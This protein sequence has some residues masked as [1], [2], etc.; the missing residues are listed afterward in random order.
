MSLRPAFMILSSFNLP[1]L[2]PPSVPLSLC[3]FAVMRHGRIVERGTHRQLIAA[4]GMY[5][6]LVRHQQLQSDVLGST[7]TSGSAGTG[8]GGRRRDVLVGSVSDAASDS[9]LESLAPAGPGPVDAAAALTGASASGTTNMSASS[10]A[11]LQQSRLPR[12]SRQSAASNGAGAG[13]ACS[14]SADAVRRAS[15]GRGGASATASGAGAASGAGRAK[16]SHSRRPGTDA[17]SASDAVST[18]QTAGAAP[19]SVPESVPGPAGGVSTGPVLDGRCSRLGVRRRKSSRP[20][21][22]AV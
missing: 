18:A 16:A 22:A 10:T 14:S 1:L 11:L 20:P 2:L 12:L 19:D 21:V 3:P 6:R 7:A 17:D 13:A 4:N 8:S 9:D 15:P 5:A